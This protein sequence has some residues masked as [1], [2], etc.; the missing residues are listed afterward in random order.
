MMHLSPSLKRRWQ[1]RTDLLETLL[2][3]PATTSA[4]AYSLDENLTAVRWELMR[5]YIFGVITPVGIIEDDV[6]DPDNRQVSFFYK[7]VLWEISEHGLHHQDVS[8]HS[9]RGCR[10]RIASASP[11]E[12]GRLRDEIEGAHGTVPRFQG[13]P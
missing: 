10:A 4:L 8:I 3:K 9:C 7:D 5:L 2:G 12:L 11:E 13:I 1:L 6:P